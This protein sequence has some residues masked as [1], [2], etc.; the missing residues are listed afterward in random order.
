MSSVPISISVGSVSSARSAIGDA[1]NSYRRVQY[2]IAESSVASFRDIR[3]D[4]SAAEEGEC[5][6]AVED[7]DETPEI[8]PSSSQDNDAFISQLSW[9]EELENSSLQVVLEKPP[10]LQQHRISATYRIKDACDE[11]TP[12]LPN[13]YTPGD[14][15][16]NPVTRGD[17]SQEN[18]T[19]GG[20]YHAIRTMER[21][22]SAVSSKSVREFHAG[23]STFG[24]SLFNTTAIL[25]GIGVLSEPLAFA[26]TGWITGTFLLILYAFVSCYTAK[27]LAKEIFS[28]SRLRTFADIGRKA[29]G[30]RSHLTI[31]FLFS[32]ELFAVS[33]VLVTLY[34][35]SLHAIFPQYASNTYKVLGAL[36]LIPTV[37]LP[38]SLLSFTSILGIISSI[39][40][41]AVV[42]VDGLSKKEAP[43]SLWDPAETHLG[44]QSFDKLGIAFGLFMAGFAGHA[45]IPS[46]AR[47]M[48]DPSRFNTMVNWAFVATT[49]IYAAI[50]Y[51]GYLM[52]GNS[53]SDEI[54]QDLLRIKGYNSILN[55]AALWMLVINPISK[56]ALNM[57]PLNATLEIML[58]SND[59]KLRPKAS[60][61]E[62][63]LQKFLAGFRRIV[64]TIL[65]IVVSILFPEFSVVMAFLG[66]FSAFI[67]NIVG[68]V[69]AKVTMQGRCNVFD[70]SIIIVGIT[71]AIW[72]TYAAFTAR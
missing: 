52:F 45:V 43:G 13:S 30:Q 60:P 8:P 11:D 42:F 33:V 62:S 5:Q 17:A 4:D 63:F 32:L 31:S 51:A 46:L 2:L 39:T 18:L 19:P 65:A 12:L 68:P 55:Q 23:H 27:I 54:S 9:D 48:K 64:L 16:R 49:F 29:F 44:I 40:L 41:V 37:F 50:G 56:F 1:L 47:D 22:P 36:I 14:S 71:M 15:S 21:R 34:A 35:D 53:V 26:Y 28:D 59:S 66:S 70:G 72:G 7:I 67:I 25:L 3:D 58:G 24:Q 57:Q 10:K 38:L 20:T 6:H 69:A 61:E